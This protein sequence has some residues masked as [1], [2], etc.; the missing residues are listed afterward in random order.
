M[1]EV[2]DS[3]TIE[4]L[5]WVSSGR[6]TY[7]EVMA[8]WK[9][10]C[11][12]H[13]VW[14]NAIADGLVQVEGGGTQAQAK[15]TLTP[16]GRAIL[17]GEH[18]PGTAPGKM[19]TLKIDIGL[20][21]HEFERD[22]DA[23]DYVKTTYLDLNTGDLHTVYEEDED[24]DNE[25]GITADENAELRQRVESRPDE[26]LEI[27]GLVHAEHHDVLLDF[28]NS[29]WTNDDKARAKALDAYSGSIGR[30][31]RAVPRNVVHAYHDFCDTQIQHMAENFLREHG[32]APEWK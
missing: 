28:L 11:P 27:P 31:K 5:T 12:R 24:A 21:M 26:Y 14:E 29:R 25:G 2:A 23:S 7:G 6:R 17:D 9:S 4:L 8:A 1:A 22:R 13:P 30:W 15:V 20:F 16:R 18:G 19:R 3:L 32:I 10:S